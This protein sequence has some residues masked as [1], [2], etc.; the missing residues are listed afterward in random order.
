MLPKVI[1][2][3]SVSLDGSLTNFEPDMG[4]HYRIAAGYKPGAHLIGSNTI[5]AGLELYGEGVQK[6]EEQDF[7]KPERS[8]SLPYWVIVDGKGSLKGVLHTCRRFEYCRD[9]IIV[10]CKATPADYID[11]LRERSYGYH[12]IGEDRVD[13]EGALRLVRSEYGVKNVLTD[14]G[15]ILGNLL[16]ERGLASE[17][18]LLVH[19]VIVGEKAYPIFGGM[20]GSLALRLVKKETFPRGLVWLVYRIAK[21][22]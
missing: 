2:H 13:L 20:H 15:R 18:S 1:I 10:G 7:Q 11:H 19:P 12:S 21:R 17:L 9:V 22:G 5:K 6:E 8:P 16:L 3:N 14:T 4:L